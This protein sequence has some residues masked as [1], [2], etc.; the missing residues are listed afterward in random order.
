M[1][2]LRC[3]SCGGSAPGR[4]WHNRDTG[5]GICPRCF[6]AWIKKL[7]IEEAI[8]C[9]GMPGIHH[10]PKT[11]APAVADLVE[12]L[13]GHAAD[14][15]RLSEYAR[16][17][18]QEKVREVYGIEAAP[19]PA[20]PP[21]WYDFGPDRTPL[22]PDFIAR[23]EFLAERCGR[24]PMQ[25]YTLW[26]EYSRRQEASGMSSLLSEFEEWYLGGNPA[27]QFNEADC[28]GAFDGFQVTSD[29]D[30]GL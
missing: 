6:E 23:I 9:C 2:N 29:A 10:S 28:G 14:S 15:A 26:Q 17:R 13:V 12:I 16:E 18:L 11:P 3:C 22:A 30:P 21:A 24:T 20:A 5:Y 27:H 4:Q 7:G 25:V 1:K 19:E 8:H